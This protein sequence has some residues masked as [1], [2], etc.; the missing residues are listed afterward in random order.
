M[1]D[2]YEL[3][4]VEPDATKDEIKAAY[5]SEVES[6]D[7]A[8]RAQLNRAWN[9]LSDPIQ[10]QR[11][12]EQ[13]ASAG[14]GDDA[15]VTDE[16]GDAGG[17]QVAARRATG[18]RRGPDSKILK[19]EATAATTNG[20]AKNGAAKGRDAEKDARPVG[21]QPLEPTVELPDGMHLAT[22]KARGMS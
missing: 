21:R 8:R 15:D 14:D 3:F 6:A 11:Y 4:G 5:R 16:V 17:S 7:S 2:H 10:R 19:A 22:K 12:D 13:I 18:A 9:V 20:A 1:S